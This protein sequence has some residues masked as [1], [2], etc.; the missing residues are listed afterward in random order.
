MIEDSSP[1]YYLIACGTSEY[2]DD[3][4]NLPQ[5]PHDLDRVS[6]VLIEQ[7]GYQRLFE[8]RSLNFEK[9]AMKD[10]FQEWLLS[11]ERSPADH[12]IFYFSGHGDYDSKNQHYLI[13]NQTQRRVLRRLP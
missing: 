2:S 8:D 7:Y 1:N 4:Q 12:V 10:D 9:Q 11:E 13:L 3:Y 5:V 6:E